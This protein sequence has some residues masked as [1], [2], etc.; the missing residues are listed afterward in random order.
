MAPG[1]EVSIAWNGHPTRAWVPERLSKR[2]LSLNERAVRATERAAALTGRASDALPPEWEPLARLLLRSEGVASSA[3]EGVRAPVA[4]IAAAE[5]EP[6]GDDDAAWI[7]DNLAAVRRSI[8]DAHRRPLD[9]AALNRWHRA[10]MSNTTRLPRRLI[11]RPRDTQGWIGGT[12]PLDAALVTPP[13]ARV[14]ALL[15]DLVAFANRTDVDAVTQAAVAHAQFE[16]IHPYADGNGR[17]GRVLAGWVLTRRLHVVNPPPISTGIARDRG[18]YLSGLTLFRLG[19]VDPWVR[20]FADVVAGAAEASIVLVRD[21]A[22]LQARWDER[23]GRVRVDAT[24][25]R[26]VRLLPAHPVIAASTVAGALA[27]SER[28]ARS[29]LTTLADAGIV[30]GYEP[31]RRARGR[32]RRWWVAQELLDL[33]TEWAR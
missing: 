17:V 6:A 28:A 29:A 15:D 21:V 22:E 16:V 26:V 18:G 32:P 27:I 7:A 12:S 8:A 11:G 23:L 20:W 5:L 10:L 1:R 14:G 24:A 13:P 33:V 4:A 3:I 19:D 31:A 9:V 25:R 2:D 30:D